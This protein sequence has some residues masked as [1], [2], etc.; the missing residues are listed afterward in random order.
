MPSISG[1]P[2]SFASV[3]ATS[4][5]AQMRVCC[6]PES[7]PGPENTSGARDCTTSS[8]PCWPGCRP[9]AY[10]FGLTTMSG[11]FGLSN[12]C[13]IRSYA[14]GWLSCSGSMNAFAGSVPEKPDFGR[15]FQLLRHR[16]EPRRVL[17]RDRVLADLL[18]NP[19]AISAVR[20]VEAA[21]ADHS[22]LRPNL[23]CARIVGLPVRR[24]CGSRYAGT[25]SRGR[26]AR[27]APGPSGAR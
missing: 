11:A 18:D 6:R 24:P 7:R 20:G 14:S 26:S 16:R 25:S 21:E 1:K 13:A 10:D 22:P 19:V 8:D 27:P 15:C 23:V 3:G 9:N 2:S 5:W 17:V 12:S 4:T